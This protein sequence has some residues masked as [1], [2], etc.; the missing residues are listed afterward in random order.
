MYIPLEIESRKVSELNRVKDKSE[1]FT[2]G[3]LADPLW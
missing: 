1:I 2:T 3:L